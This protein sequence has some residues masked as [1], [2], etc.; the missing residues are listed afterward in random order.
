MWYMYAIECYSAVKR[1]KIESS[2]VTWMG[3]ASVIQGEVNQE[4]ENKYHILAL[5]CGIW[6][7]GTDKPICRARI[8]MQKMG[9]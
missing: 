4:G 5:I 3:L 7:N 8:E 9:M 2:V 6:K 1:T